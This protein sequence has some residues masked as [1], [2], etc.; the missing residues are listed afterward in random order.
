MCYSNHSFCINHVIAILQLLF[1]AASIFNKLQMRQLRTYR[2]FLS[3]LLLLY[4]SLRG[5]FVLVQ[6]A[7][8]APVCPA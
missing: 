4:H 6:R 3:F 5:I 7:P 8:I 2:I 1:K